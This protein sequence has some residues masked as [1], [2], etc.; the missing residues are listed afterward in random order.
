MLIIS[1]IVFGMAASAES[2]I[3]VLIGEKWLPCVPMMQIMSFT[4]VLYPLHQI[5]INMLTVQ[6][7]SDILLILQVVKCIIAVGPVFCGI[8]LG[9][10]W[11]L[12]GSAVA[13]WLSFFLNAYYSGRKFCYTWLMQ[14]KDILPS[15]GIAFAMAIPVYLLSFIPLSPYILFPFQIIIGAIIVYF[16]CEKA[17]LKEYLELKKILSR[18]M[19]RFLKINSNV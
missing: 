11:M 4:F 6:G 17:Q 19:N 14:L 1:I 9:I 8:Y 16:L 10:Y 7:R 5:N 3:Y 18:D 15:L 12:I 2:M 13:S